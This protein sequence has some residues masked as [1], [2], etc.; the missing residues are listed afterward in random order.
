M[1]AIGTG[2]EAMPEHP[3]PGAAD[4]QTRLTRC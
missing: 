4:Q 2:I 3:T 1:T